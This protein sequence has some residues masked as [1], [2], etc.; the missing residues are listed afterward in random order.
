MANSNGAFTVTIN[1]NAG[2]GETG[3]PHIENTEIA[4]ALRQIAQDVASGVPSRAIKDRNGNSVGTYAYG[5][6][7]INVGR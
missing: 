1:T 5:S 2:Y 4:F 7:M 3:K 6:G